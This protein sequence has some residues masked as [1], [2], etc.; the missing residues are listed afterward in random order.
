MSD[1]ELRLP[2]PGEPY[3]AHVVIASCIGNDTPEDGSVFNTLLIINES[4]PYYSL[5]QAT[6]EEGITVLESFENIIPAA[7]AYAD[8]TGLDRE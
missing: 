4:K 1:G 7:L 8:A 6:I 3:G 5:V 2:L